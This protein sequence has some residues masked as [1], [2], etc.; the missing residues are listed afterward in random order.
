LAFG[1]VDGFG[2][3]IRLELFVS[4]GTLLDRDCMDGG[5]KM[6]LVWE[7]LGLLVVI[8]GRLCGSELGFG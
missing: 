2:S 3:E 6:R 7:E 8:G 4:V 1:V 5:S